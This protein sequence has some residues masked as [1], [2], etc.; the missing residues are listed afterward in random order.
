MYCY[1]TERFCEVDERRP[2]QPNSLSSQSNQDTEQ[3]YK[4]VNE[5]V[6]KIPVE[7]NR[8]QHSM[9]ADNTSMEINN[10]HIPV[11]EQ[12]S[13]IDEK[14][15]AGSQNLS[16]KRKQKRPAKV[17]SHPTLEDDDD[18]T[19]DETQIYSLDDNVK[20]NGMGYEETFSQ[21]LT[22]ESSSPVF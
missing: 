4:N 12:H 3:D 9:S 6:P 11:E 20:G 14:P 1:C 10:R 22:M 17:I 5:Q 21:N 7:D 16:R 18:I 19:D 2:L 15:L 8:K 13:R